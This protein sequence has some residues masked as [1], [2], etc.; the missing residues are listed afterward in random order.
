M[1]KRATAGLGAGVLLL[2]GLLAGCGG[3]DGDENSDTDA[4]SAEGGEFAEQSY[5]EIKSQAIEAMD[6]LESLHVE[7]EV[8]AQ[9]QTL[10]TDL[11]MSVEGLC[12]G[13]VSL[14]AATAELLK[15]EDGAWFRPNADYLATEYPDQ[16]EK[17]IKFIGDSWV[18]DPE[19]SVVGGNCDLEGFVD[20][21]SDD[22]DESDTEVV[23]VEELDGQEV[24]RLDYT[25]S[26]GDGSAYVLVDG[27]H[28]IVRVENSGDQNGAAVFSAFN[29][30]VAPET[31]AD[32]EV[33]D[34]AD[35]R[36]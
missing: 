19:E 24:V 4:G 26:V 3:D 30:E 14:G 27:E 12:E 18:A 34:L 10:A 33:V 21:I 16:T 7:F 32:D 36:G 23:G 17:V 1:T 15:T 22:E 20:S 28:Y 35:F 25:N 6:S 9:E 11:S 31:P 5:E 29:E 2:A 8:T 13:S